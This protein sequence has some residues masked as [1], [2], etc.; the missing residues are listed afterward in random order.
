MRLDQE[1][2]KRAY[3]AIEQTTGSQREVWMRAAEGL[4]PEIQRAGLLQ[5]LAF[6]HRGPTKAI[7]PALC[8]AIREHLVGRGHLSG[9]GHAQGFLVE[10]RDLGRTDYMRITRE[11]LAL[12]IWFKRAAQVLKQEDKKGGSHA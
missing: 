6:L 1:R 5:A 2:M 8:A 7:A 11:V 9:T 10:V 3:R 12:S 4:G